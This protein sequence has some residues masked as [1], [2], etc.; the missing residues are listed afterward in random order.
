VEI[1]PLKSPTEEFDGDVVTYAELMQEFRLRH[2]QSILLGWFESAE[3]ALLASGEL[4]G[5][6]LKAV[7][8]VTL[9][10]CVVF[11]W[12]CEVS[13]VRFSLGLTQRLPLSSNFQVSTCRV[14]SGQ[15][16]VRTP[17]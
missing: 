4:R 14:G 1:D 7:K 11:A 16:E 17:Q 3:A 10:R 13:K 2:Y 6:D 5:S 8:N 9:L 12:V 15:T